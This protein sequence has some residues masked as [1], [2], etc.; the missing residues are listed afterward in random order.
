MAFGHKFFPIRLALLL[1]LVCTAPLLR[2]QVFTANHDG[3]D[4][5]D[6]LF[7][8]PHG[9][10]NTAQPAAQLAGNNALPFD[11]NSTQLPQ[12][13]QTTISKPQER[14]KLMAYLRQIDVDKQQGINTGHKK[15]YYHLA[16]TFARLRL[17][18]LAMKCFLKTLEPTKSATVQPDSL[19]TDTAALLASGL[20]FSSVDDTL[21]A[22]RP[23]LQVPMPLQQQK[24]KPIT[25]ERI[26]QTFN[27]G[28]KAVAYAMLIHVKQPVPGTRKVYQFTNSGHT[29][30][31]LIKYNADSSYVS[32]SFGFYPKKQHLLAGT[33]IWPSAN[34]L[35]RNDANYKW[36][37]VAGKF[38]SQKRF[39][40]IL[41]LTQKYDG[42]K[43]HLS[44]NN[45]TDFSL[46][47]ALM[48][49]IRIGETTGSWPLGHGNNPGIT[50]QSML[51]GNVF[52]GTDS[53]G[54][55]LDNDVK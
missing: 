23:V 10:Y 37:E 40:K 55:F 51:N 53:T 49:D 1:A 46:K 43:Y 45:C 39:K 17:Y 44:T 4:T 30:I 15:L 7:I 33:P 8:S 48:A 16:N 11:I 6:R 29:Y 12:Q 20:N 22:T 14:K 34:S 5:V 3:A 52:N 24:S 36:D 35:Y 38:I 42:V 18:P 9:F 2:A 25:Y 50:G 47:A 28:K 13:L 41:A 26:A 54:L 27:D 31:T 21:L 32:L 19:A